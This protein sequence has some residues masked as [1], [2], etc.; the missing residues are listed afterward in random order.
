MGIYKFISNCLHV[1]SKIIALPS[2]NYSLSNCLNTLTNW[3]LQNYLMLII[4]KTSIN[5][6]YRVTSIFPLVI[7]NGKIISLQIML[8]ILVLFLIFS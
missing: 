5:N 7:I 8:K 1:C 6:C 2:D 3:F 4:S